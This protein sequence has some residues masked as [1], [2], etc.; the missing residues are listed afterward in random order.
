MLDQDQGRGTRFDIKMSTFETLEEEKED[1]K[2]EK[3]HLNKED[4]K[5]NP[6]QGACWPDPDPESGILRCDDVTRLNT[7]CVDRIFFVRNLEDIQRVLQLAKHEG[8]R[9]SVR[10]TQHSMGGHTIAKDGYV[11]DM[12]RLNNVSYDQKLSLVKCGAGATWADLISYLNSYGRSPRTMQSYSVFSVG[13]SVAVNAHGITT[14]FTVAESIVSILVVLHDGSVKECSRKEN[15]EL[16]RLV[17]GGFGLFGIIVKVVM[18]TVPNCHMDMQVLQLS[19]ND[20]PS[21]YL[22]LLKRNDVAMKMGRINIFNMNEIQLFVF[23]NTSNYNTPTVSKLPLV[24]REMGML[25]KLAYKWLMPMMN[26][27]RFLLEKIMGSSVDWDNSVLERNLMM[28]ESARPLAELFQPLLQSD[29]TFVLQEYFIPKLRF[30]EWI[31]RVKPI[32]NEVLNDYPGLVLLNTTIRFVRADKEI[33]LSYAP[34]DSWAFVL[35]FRIPRSEAGDAALKKIHRKFVKATL[36]V[37]GRF[38]LPY[39]RHYTVNEICES[40]PEIKNFFLCKTKFDPDG[41]FDNLWFREYGLKVLGNESDWSKAFCQMRPK[42]SPEVSIIIKNEAYSFPTVSIS[43]SDSY[44]NLVNNPLMRRKFEEQ[45]LK[46]I[47][48]VL[49]PKSLMNLITKATWD[50]SAKNDIEVYRI[51]RNSLIKERGVITSIKKTWN[52]IN[53]LNKQKTEIAREMAVIIGRLSKI[54]KIHDYVS[55]GDNGKVVNG[56]KKLIGMRGQTW[57]VHSHDISIS[58]HSDFVAKGTCDDIAV[59]LERGSLNNVGHNVFID[60]DNVGQQ[61][62]IPDQCSDLVSVN[63]GL[64]HFKQDNIM[65]FL[66]EVN[67]ILRPG[68]LLIIREHNAYPELIP[69]LDLAHSIFNAV[70][71]VSV[72]EEEAEIRAFRPIE[73]W[74]EIITKSGLQDSYLYEMEPE[75][76]TVD[77][78]LCFFKPPLHGG[79]EPKRTMP[80]KKYLEPALMQPGWQLEISNELPRSALEFLKGI[81]DGVRES[82]PK[83]EKYIKSQSSYLSPGQ[84]T[85]VDMLIGQVINPLRTMISK[86]QPILDSSIVDG[87]ASVELIPPEVFLLVPALLQK[88]KRGKASAG[89]MVAISLIKDFGLAIGVDNKEENDEINSRS[90]AKDLLKKTPEVSKQL[91]LEVSQEE[92]Q[93]V[94][95][96]V[97]AAIPDL[98][99]PWKIKLRKFGIGK[100]A[101]RTLLEILGGMDTQAEFSYALANYLDLKSWSK[102]KTALFKAEE[103]KL[104]PHIGMITEYHVDNPW[105]EAMMALLS[106]SRVELKKRAMLGLSWVGLGVIPTMYKA[107]QAMRREE[108]AKQDVNYLDGVMNEKVLS[109]SRWLDHSDVRT[110]VLDAN[111]LYDLTEVDEIISAFYGQKSLTASMDDITEK[112]T[113][114]YLKNGRLN[115]RGRNIA[116]DLGVGRNA[117]MTGLRSS[118][119]FETKLK[120]KY[121]SLKQPDP[122]M[123]LPSVN[124]LLD[125]LR[126]L[127]LTENVSSS[128]GPWNWY[129]LPEWMQ[130]EICQ[131]FGEFLEHTPWFRFPYMRFIGTYFKTLFK[132]A[133]VVQDMYGFK[134]AFGASFLTMAVPGILMTGLFA[135]LEM[136]AAP[137]R[138]MYSAEGSP[139]KSGGPDGYD[140]EQLYEQ[141][142][143]KL[144]TNLNEKVSWEEIDNRIAAKSLTGGLFLLKVPTFKGMTEVLCALARALPAG[145]VLEISGHR[146]VQVKILTQ[147][148]QQIEDLEN[149]VGCEVL[150]HFKYPVSGKPI[151]P[152][153]NVSCR[154]DIPYLLYFIRRCDILGCKVAQIYDWF[155]GGTDD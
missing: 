58:T 28:F 135:Q 22:N 55:I 116:K 130:V 42:L 61:L 153:Y 101:L 138:Y 70:T 123:F 103:Q 110:V 33:E 141:V 144:P 29:D 96:K 115:L 49:D 107:A 36:A 94:I 7:T 108:E 127:N 102:L 63:A 27:Q 128:A 81:T 18:T 112:F 82:L 17:I 31:T 14:D 97:V 62:D 50:S 52:Q 99:L 73:S 65:A 25:K 95:N 72:K 66:A 60:Y 78:M 129:K 150:F 117:F 48:H 40:Y 105:R 57:V 136:L 13:G 54:G 8:R 91:E 85:V 131:I 86:F 139:M 109:A 146:K 143:M 120:V 4:G 37:E 23:R 34:T 100:T 145:R 80:L 126:K 3:Y 93:E 2:E 35:Y 132:E 39:R 104:F 11:I 124:G 90:P 77:E 20:F 106:S 113:K 6:L 79:P 47:F 15:N 67:R 19:I 76:P 121:R 98:G 149:V 155:Y 142:V 89:E 24:P 56:L 111:N 44:Q 75:D 12:A 69:M 9:I 148:E 154:V 45:F 92:V 10:G 152:N 74:R 38:Y 133:K 125:Q 64:H 30:K 114:F 88:V 53:Q 46:N 137:V 118:I 83:V 147:T 84:R 122:M 5:S 134:K 68:G 16:F 87:A 32:Y 140:P 59:I 1:R 119:G 41:V 43:R 71:G 151:E 21:I 51:L 26:D